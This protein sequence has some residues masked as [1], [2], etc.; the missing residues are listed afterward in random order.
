MALAHAAQHLEGDLGAG[1][2]GALQ[3]IRMQASSHG[4]SAMHFHCHRA[5]ETQR[6][7]CQLVNVTRRGSG[8]HFELNEEALCLLQLLPVSNDLLK[9]G[10]LLW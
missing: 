7:P 1:R 2:Q 4:A 6:E 3:Q 9:L 5:Q 8:W 10:S